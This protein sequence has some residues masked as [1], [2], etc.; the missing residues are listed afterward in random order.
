MTACV[1]LGCERPATHTLHPQYGRP[2][3][4]CEEHGRVAL[5]VEEQFSNRQSSGPRLTPE[6]HDW[7]HGLVAKGVPA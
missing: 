3:R 5:A 7:V 1:R 4:W 6:R 2:S